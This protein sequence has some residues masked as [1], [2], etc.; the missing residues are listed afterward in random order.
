MP[1]PRIRD[2]WVE[3]AG[4]GFI[5]FRLA[6]GVALLPVKD[7]LDAGDSYRQ[8]PTLQRFDSGRIRQRQPNGAFARGAWSRRCIRCFA[9]EPTGFAGHGVQ[10]EYYVNDAGRQMHIILAASVWLRCYQMQLG[11]TLPFPTN[12][13]QGDYI[14]DGQAAD[15]RGEVGDQFAVSAD[16]ILTDSP[17]DAPEGDKEAYIDVIARGKALHGDAGWIDS[18]APHWTAFWRVSVRIWRTS[19]SNSINGLAKNH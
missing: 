5:N 10:R 12:G 3:I 1:C 9:F 19:V 16:D 14:A 18:A 6:Q 15:L 7:A 11:Q 13:Y 8:G 17:P 2:H 4:P